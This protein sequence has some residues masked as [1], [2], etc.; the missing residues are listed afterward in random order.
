MRPTARVG[1]AEPPPSDDFAAAV[2]ESEAV[3]R[4]IG[5]GSSATNGR[6]TPNRISATPLVSRQWPQAGRGNGKSVHRR[7]ARQ[8]GGRRDGK[9]AA[10][11]DFAGCDVV[12]QVTDKGTFCP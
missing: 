12:A 2:E 3:G 1:R 5:V 6:D 8:S 10:A 9:N 7:R 11:G 4:V